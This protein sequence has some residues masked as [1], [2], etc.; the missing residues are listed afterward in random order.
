MSNFIPKKIIDISLALEEGMITYP[1]NPPFV[2]EDASGPTSSRSILTIGTH[3]GTHIDAPRHVFK[4]GKGLEKIPL[5]RY[6]GKCRVLDLTKAKESVTVSDLE[7]FRI[8]SG[9]RILVKTRN[10]K[11]GFKTFYSDYVYLDGDAADY[12]VKKGITLFGIDSLSVK[13]RGGTDHRPHLALLKK[14]IVIFEGLNLSKATEGTYTFIGLP[15]K[16]GNID[17][18]PARAILIQ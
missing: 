10:S 4:D 15:L 16:L 11:R 7:T 8:K 17:G 1:D 9:E 2:I 3:T 12:L 18:A 13:K 6:V 14:G 5:V